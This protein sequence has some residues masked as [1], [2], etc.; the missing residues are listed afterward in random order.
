MS[1][2]TSV[3]PY[4][5][6]TVGTGTHFLDT[7]VGPCFEP[8]SDYD[9]TVYYPNGTDWI[10]PQ[11][12]PG[13]TDPLTI[14]HTASIG[15][16]VATVSANPTGYGTGN[17]AYGAYTYSKVYGSLLAVSSSGVITTTGSLSGLANTFVTVGID[18]FD[19]TR[20][21]TQLFTVWVT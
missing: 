14:S 3:P 10:I 21:N 20:H 17:T 15:A 7:T 11:Q 9:D 5:L 16:T 8:H 1:F 2:P 18:A 12:L 13:K 19:G 4:A 6:P